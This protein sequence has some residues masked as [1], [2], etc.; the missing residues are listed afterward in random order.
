MLSNFF[1]LTGLVRSGTTLLARCCDAHPQITCASDPLFGF[2]RCLRNDLRK[3]WNIEG[4]DPAEPLSDFFFDSKGEL[5]RLADANLHV[6]VTIDHATLTKEIARFADATGNAPAIVPL[7]NKLNGSTYA[8]V[9]VQL[10]E[11]L[12]AAYGSETDQWSGFKQTWVEAFGGTILNTWPEAHVVHLVRDPRA[13]IASWRTAK[14]LRHDY[15]FLMIVRHWR[16]SVAVASLFSRRYKNYTVS[17]YEDLV[18]EPEQEIKKIAAACGFPVDQ[19]M[20]DASRFRSEDGGAWKANTSHGGP[21]D[22]IASEKKDRWKE[23]L[24]I[25]EIQLIEDLCDLELKWMGYARVTEPGAPTSFLRQ[26]RLERAVT[27]PTPWM[28]SFKGKYEFDAN[29]FSQELTRWFLQNQPASVLPEQ[30][31]QQIYLDPELI[32]PSH[33]PFATAQ[34]SL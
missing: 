31:R 28:D 20:L 5:L 4:G 14:F 17:S 22:K 29:N 33:R 8:E 24:A 32:T 18:S 21:T 19:Q 13:V 2:F 15:P 3:T 1:F 11:M 16:K 27:G 34:G 12:K 6:P 26:L 10:V 23:Q 30:L 7:L 25:E 9:F